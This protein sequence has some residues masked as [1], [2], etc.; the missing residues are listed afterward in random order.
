MVWYL[1]IILKFC[2]V[3]D[4]P[5]SERLKN[6]NL[7]TYLPSLSCHRD[8]MDLIMKYKIF[9]GAALVDKD[10][11]LQAIILDQIYCR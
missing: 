9:N 8:R 5:Y 6:L 11:F 3:R 4:L 2:Q 7:P 10:Y 1:A